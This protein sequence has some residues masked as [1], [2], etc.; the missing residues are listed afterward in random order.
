MPRL[1]P[2]ITIQPLSRG[3]T[4]WPDLLAVVQRS[5]AP[6]NGVVDPPSSALRLTAES[7]CAKA[8]QET[9]FHASIGGRIVGC[10]FVA[11]RESH[12]YVG[13]LAVDPDMHGLGIGRALMK[14]A[15]A[16]A[17]RRGKP[18]L[19]LQTRVELEANHIVFRRLGFR[20]TG[21]T[22]HPGYDRPTSVTMR[23]V[24]A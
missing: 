23:K 14:A 15:E 4:R 11:E 9:G 12:F 2:G 24:L 8:E 3:F 19:E 21:R 5:F 16:L 20:E 18:S 7:L 22:A 13:K 10:V 17:L 1:P 6:M